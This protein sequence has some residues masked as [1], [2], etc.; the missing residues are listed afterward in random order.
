MSVETT[1]ETEGK[2]MEKYGRKQGDS[3]FEAAAQGRS[4]GR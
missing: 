3:F 2:G 4:V 1:T